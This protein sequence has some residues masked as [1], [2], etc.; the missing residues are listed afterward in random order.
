V[1]TKQVSV[2]W[3]LD[4]RET[5]GAMKDK[6]WLKSTETN[7]RALFKP[8]EGCEGERS[9]AFYQVCAHL[10]IDCAKTELYEFEGRQGSLS[11]DV[12]HRRL[13]SNEGAELD[14]KSGASFIRGKTNVTYEDLEPN[15]PNRVDESV[16][17]NG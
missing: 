13:I 12:G 10:G 17:R 8:D 16:G 11:Y 1:N 4:S 2:V 3:I 15:L 9:L 14:I 5:R 7:E 6:V